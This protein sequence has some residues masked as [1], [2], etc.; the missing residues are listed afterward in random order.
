IW[1]GMKF[2]TI[3]FLKF[4]PALGSMIKPTSQFRTWYAF[5]HP[6]IE[7]QSFFLQTAGPQPIYQHS[8]ATFRKRCIVNTSNINPELYLSHRFLFAIA[9]SQLVRASAT[10]SRISNKP[11]K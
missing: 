10:E 3:P 4:V 6:G 1:L 8:E 2:L 5:L 11:S 7:L 9:S